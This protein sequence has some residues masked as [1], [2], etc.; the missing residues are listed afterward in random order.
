[1]EIAMAKSVID[2]AV[3][4]LGSLL[5]SGAIALP[6]MSTI[7]TGFAPNPNVGW[8]SVIADY[9]QPPAG[10]GPVALDPNVP[11]VTNEEFRRTGRQPTI[12]VG[13]PNSPILQ[14][15]A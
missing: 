7:P 4:I 6:V 2:C 10:P 12:A 8:I 1:M 3:V 14:P 11:H 13:D 9:S 5:C 15:W